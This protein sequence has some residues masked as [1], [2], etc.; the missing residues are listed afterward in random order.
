MAGCKNSDTLVVVRIRS[1]TVVF[2]DGADTDNVI[3]AG[4][5]VS[6]R[7]LAGEL[8]IDLPTGPCSF[9]LTFVTG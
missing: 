5:V 7:I 4:S 6:V 8:M 3:I 2:S 1:F 9:I